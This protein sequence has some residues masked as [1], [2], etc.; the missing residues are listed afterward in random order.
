MKRIT[1]LVSL[2]LLLTS[3]PALAQQHTASLTAGWNY[4]P[5]SWERYIEGPIYG[6]D[7]TW[8]WQGVHTQNHRAPFLLGLKANMAYAPNGIAGNRYG[9]SAFATTP[10]VLVF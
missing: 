8:E 5:N 6:F 4:S 10:F 7:Y 1:S 3:L 9:V 2:M